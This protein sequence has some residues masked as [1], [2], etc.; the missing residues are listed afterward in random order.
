MR[1]IKNEDILM[2][3]SKKKIF[4]NLIFLFTLSISTMAQ[5]VNPKQWQCN[6]DYE[7]RN[8]QEYQDQ[9]KNPCGSKGMETAKLD[10]L[11]DN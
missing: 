9:S 5:D 2:R 3:M 11:N 1:I 4:T 8:G 7:N 6:C 10:L